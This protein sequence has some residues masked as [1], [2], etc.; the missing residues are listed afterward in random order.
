MNIEIEFISIKVQKMQAYIGSCKIFFS[1]KFNN[2]N[3]F[4]KK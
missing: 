3:G 4:L 2:L 1:F